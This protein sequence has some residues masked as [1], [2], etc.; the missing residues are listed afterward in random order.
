M[1][2]NAASVLITGCSTDV[3]I[4]VFF[5]ERRHCSSVSRLET[6]TYNVMRSPTP[7]LHVRSLK[8]LGATLEVTTKDAINLSFSVDSTIRIG[9]LGG[10]MVSTSSVSASESTHVSNF[11][12]V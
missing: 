10:T 8:Q 2:T 4:T 5:S 7:V 12:C 6:S 11:S 1:S 9:S 3:G